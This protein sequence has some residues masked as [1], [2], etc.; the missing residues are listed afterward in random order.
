MRYAKQTKWEEDAK[1]IVEKVIDKF[2]LKFVEHPYLHRVEH[3]IHCEL[4][5]ML[6]EQKLL[7]GRYP[8][9]NDN[10]ETQLIHKEWPECIG[11]NNHRRGNIDLCVLSPESLKCCSI[12]Q[13]RIGNIKPVI[14][15]EIGLDY[16][17]AHLMKDSE[18]LKN[19]QIING[20]LIH[21]V[22]SNGNVRIN[23]IKEYVKDCKYKI[24]CAVLKKG[25]VVFK[26]LIN[27]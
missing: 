10:Y 15:I 18:K 8:I 4:F 3:S 7:K 26:K 22:R 24:G 11:R 16:T 2:I 21:L 12:E 23:D 14:A 9:D 25:K 19:S 13:Y 5:K 6:L 1:I 27:P 17:L 20:Y